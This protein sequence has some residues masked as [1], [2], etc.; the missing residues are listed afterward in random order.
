MEIQVEWASESVLGMTAFMN[1]LRQLSS[2]FLKQSSGV[3]LQAFW[4]L[5]FG[6]LGPFGSILYQAVSIRLHDGQASKNELTHQQLYQR[7]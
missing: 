5:I 3:V 1:S 2:N 4:K 6:C 7:K